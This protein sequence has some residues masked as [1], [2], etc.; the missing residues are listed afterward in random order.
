MNATIKA[1]CSNDATRLKTYITQ[2]ASPDPHKPG[3]LN[4]PI[5]VTNGRAELGLNHPILA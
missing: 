2:Y 3:S 1:V 5:V 4:P